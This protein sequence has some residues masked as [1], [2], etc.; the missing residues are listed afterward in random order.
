MNWDAIGALAEMIAAL[1]V[2]VT[3]LLLLKQ[4][5][6]SNAQA[7]QANELA[8][9][10]SQRDILKQV[11]GHATL[12]IDNPDLQ[13]DI[14]GCYER[15]DDAPESAKWNFESWASSYFYIVEQAI[16]MHD[17]GLLSDETYLAMEIAAIRI[18]ET[19]GGQQWWQ[20]KSKHIGAGV[21]HRINQ[22]RKEIGEGITP[23]LGLNR[24]SDTAEA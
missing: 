2:V 11:A 16:E 20:R 3:L 12:T 6:L 19:P 15:W 4:L 22:R 8:R 21:S 23:M 9:A 5:K 18:V 14:R 7:N 10:D 1:T 13:S 24:A 17:R